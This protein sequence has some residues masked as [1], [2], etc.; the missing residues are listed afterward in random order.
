LFVAGAAC[1]VTFALGLRAEE[2]K[3]DP[4]S[5]NRMTDSE[6]VA[7]GREASSA[8]EKEQ[9]LQFVTI[10]RVQNYVSGL[11][12][13]IAA[14]SRRSQLTYQTKV[15]DT[16]VVNASAW[17]GGFVYVNRGIIEWARTESELVGVL[18]HEIGHVAGR[19]GAN[20]LAR[21]SSAESLILEA[22]SRLLGT[23]APALIL[24]Q[25]GGP[26]AFMA[27]MKYSRTDELQADLL[28]FYNMQRAGWSPDGIVDL[29]KHMGDRS[30]PMDSI[31]A[32]TQS[33]PAAADRVAQI[34]NEMKQ[35]PPKGELVRDSDEFKA[36]QA[37]LKKLPKP[38][39]SN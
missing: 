16:M 13:R 18:S 15:I 31:L 7:L 10:P 17:P 32:M 36:V 6:E 12:N 26:V 11:I 21:M 3:V 33:H 2:P 14:Q 23:P 4:P 28:G 34:V 27:L 24:K 39:S 5:Y 38:S 20:N 25:I 8:Y 22:S 37:E 29:F 30:S 9:K 19:H 35:F 1:V